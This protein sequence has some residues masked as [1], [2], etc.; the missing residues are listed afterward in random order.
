MEVYTQERTTTNY[1]YQ[2][3]LPAMSEMSVCF[4]AKLDQ[5]DDD[6]VDNLL[7]TI[8]NAGLDFVSSHVTVF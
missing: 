7:V 5:D 8:F 2:H 1:L 3:G 4:W 6:R